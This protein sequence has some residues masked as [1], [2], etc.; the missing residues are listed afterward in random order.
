MQNENPQSIKTCPVCGQEW[1]EYYIE[2]PVNHQVL[3]CENCLIIKKD[4]VIQ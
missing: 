1:P 3:G 4:G 2:D